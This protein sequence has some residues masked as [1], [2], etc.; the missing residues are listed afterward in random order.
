MECL[1]RN[2]PCWGGEVQE[3]GLEWFVNM[4]LQ[5]HI[6]SCAKA[7]CLSDLWHFEAAPRGLWLVKL[8]IPLLD[9]GP[10]VL[11]QGLEAVAHFAF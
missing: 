10:T 8:S 9:V 5:E 4:S 2:T 1:C 11:T 3:L 7:S 6:H